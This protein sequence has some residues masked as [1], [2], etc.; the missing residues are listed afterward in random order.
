MIRDV[1]AYVKVLHERVSEQGLALQNRDWH[2]KCE[3]NPGRV[4]GGD[5]EDPSNRQSPFSE[6]VLCC[7]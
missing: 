4:F 5:D 7:G 6:L 1:S 3:I 2:Y